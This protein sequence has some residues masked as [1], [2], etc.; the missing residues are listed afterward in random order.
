MAYVDDG[1]YRDFPAPRDVQ[2]LDPAQ[3]QTH[4]VDWAD[5]EQ[6]LRAKGGTLYDPSDLEGIKRNTGYSVGG[7]SLDQALQNQF[8]IYDRRAAPNTSGGQ[9]TPNYQTPT[10]QW[11]AQPQTQGRSDELFK[12]LMQR[13]QQP[14]TVTGQDPNVRAQVDPVVAQQTRASR[15]YLD[16]LAER[17]G[18]LANLQGERRLAAERQGQAAGAFESEIIG[19]EISGRRDEAAQALALA[20]QQG[21][22]EQQLSA[23]KELANLDALLRREGFGLQR[24]GLGLQRDQMNL[25]NDQF[26]K[27]LALRQWN[28]ENA[29][30]YRWATGI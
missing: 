30:D 18:P 9:Q 5:V 21:N 26:L 19:R 13:A 14:T 3:A 22:L 23:Q 29:W 24:E 8:D 15:D 17:A 20:S 11:N 12:L 16:Q 27:E 28:D 1:Q 2:R 7:V 6:R 4:E 25:S 10:Q